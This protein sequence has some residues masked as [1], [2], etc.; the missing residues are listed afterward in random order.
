[1][2]QVGPIRVLPT[3]FSIWVQGTEDTLCLLEQLSASVPVGI[4]LSHGHQSPEN[5]ILNKMACIS[6][7]RQA[8][9]SPQ[10]P[11]VPFSPHPP[12]TRQDRPTACTRHSPPDWKHWVLD[13]SRS[14]LQPVGRRNC[15][16]NTQPPKQGWWWGGQDKSEACSTVTLS[17]C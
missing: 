8:Q 7:A 10:C 16:I 1:M 4:R 15:R 13:A 2:T 6:L 12:G 11:P 14:N 9:V 5:S 3:E 17:S